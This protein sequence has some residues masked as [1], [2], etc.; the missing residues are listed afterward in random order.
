MASMK[1]FGL[2]KSFNP[3]KGWGFIECPQTYELYGKDMFVLKNAL[4]GGIANKGD[5][6][7]FTVIQEHNGPV[8]ATVEVI[9]RGP[10]SLAPPGAG[11]DLGMLNVPNDTPHDGMNNNM[12]VIA[13]SNPAEDVS[14]APGYVGTIKSF[15][16]GTGWGMIAC[17][18]MMQLHGKDVFF[19]QGV[20]REGSAAQGEMVFFVVRME[21]KGPAAASVRVLSLQRPIHAAMPALPGP[22]MG[23][24]RAGYGMMGRPGVATLPQP[25]IGMMGT[26]RAPAFPQKDQ[27]FF[28][29]LKSFS[30]EKGWG[31]ITC[32][33]TNR[34]YGKDV[35]LM[36]GAL[37]GQTVNAGALLSFKVTLGSKGPQA[38]AVS[39]LPPGCFRVSAEE[40]ASVYSGTVKSFNAERGWGFVT[41]EELQQTFGKDIFLHRRDL[42]ENY[43][44]S[45]GEEIQLCVE[46]DDGGQPVA[47]NAVPL[48]PGLGGTSQLNAASW[49][50]VATNNAGTVRAAPY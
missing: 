14:C 44:P 29:V 41:S 4:P 46:I 12:Q 23:L 5:Q 24:A 42:Q 39:M 15:N 9:G 17:P 32:E 38:M 2:I 13:N 25:G 22:A 3:Q 6:V 47:K 8:A 7:A 20:V 37:N 16:S 1:Y 19:S 21:P 26:P 28:G 43:L 11:L 50:A 27:T 30:E 40:S 49:A 36:K 10:A 34:L 45:T 18:E 48:N 33:C 31:H 35:F